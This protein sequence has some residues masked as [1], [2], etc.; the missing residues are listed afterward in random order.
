MVG[1]SFAF[2]RK[3]INVVRPVHVHA[4]ARIRLRGVISPTRRRISVY[5]Y[6]NSSTMRPL[7]ECFSTS[8]FRVC[9]GGPF[10]TAVRRT[11]F[12]AFVFFV[13]FCLVAGCVSLPGAIGLA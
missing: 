2:R 1:A 13:V 10:F 8:I 6:N 7:Y 3:E 4:V 11:A 12:Y 9:D 5:G